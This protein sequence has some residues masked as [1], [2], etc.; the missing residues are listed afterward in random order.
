LTSSQTNLMGIVRGVPSAYHSNA[1]KSQ[2]LLQ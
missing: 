2:P 1:T